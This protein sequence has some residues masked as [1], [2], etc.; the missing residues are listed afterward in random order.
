MRG[1]VYGIVQGWY[2]DGVHNWGERIVNQQRGYMKQVST[3]L[4]REIHN[5]TGTKYIVRIFRTS[6]N[7]LL[8]TWT[9]DDEYQFKV[10]IEHYEPDYSI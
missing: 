10:I 7:H 2:L 6:D 4:M 9:T 8:E 5:T 3:H 1:E